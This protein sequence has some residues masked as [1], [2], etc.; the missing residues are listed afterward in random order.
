MPRNSDLEFRIER[1]KRLERA[2]RN[3]GWTR[4]QLAEKTGYDEKTIRN[5]L[6][7]EPVRDHTIVDVSNALE[8]EPQLVNPYDDVDVASDIY[9]GYLRHT[10]RNYEGF[11]YAYRRSFTRPG[12]IF[13]SVFGIEWDQSSDY[14]IFSEYYQLEAD[15]KYGAKSHDGIVYMSSYTSLVHLLTIY[16][17]SIRLATLTKMRQA[18]GIMRGAIQTQSE[19]LMFFQPSVAP[20]VLRKLKQYDPESQIKSDVRFLAEADE[21][22]KF[23]CEQIRIT[24]KQ[25]VKMAFADQPSDAHDN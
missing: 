16:E 14:L 4:V 6:A 21:D 5:L 12:E 2:L 15:E 10:H 20:I 18:D 8:V 24:E 13:R 23:A 19:S 7:G 17:G 1:A 3:K 9:G 22:Y 25:I 11:F